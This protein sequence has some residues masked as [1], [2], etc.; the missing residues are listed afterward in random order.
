MKAYETTSDPNII[1]EIETVK[2]EI[3]LDKLQAQS[4]SLKAEIAA[5]P[6]LKTKPDQETLDL[7]NAGIPEGKKEELETQLAEKEALMAIITSLK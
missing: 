6:E 5:L 2:S 1:K 7:W 4:D 3:H